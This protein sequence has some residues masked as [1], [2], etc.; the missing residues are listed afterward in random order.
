MQPTI[1][2]FA[3]GSSD[4]HAYRARHFN[5][6]DAPAMMGVS[7]YRSRT[8]LIREV[9]TGVADE[10]D[11][12]K[13]RLFDR[14]HAAEAAIRPMI[15]RLITDELYPATLS[16]DVQGL[17][18]SA[19]MDGWN[20]A[21]DTAFECK[22]WNEDLA[23]QVRNGELAPHYFWQLEQ[24]LLVSGAERVIF[25]TGDGEERLETLEYRPVPGRAEQLIAG[26]KQFEA[27]VA[28]YE[29][30]QVKAELVAA[31]IAGFGALTIRVEG[32]VLASNMD[33]F[34]ANAEAFLTQLPRPDQLQTDQDF[35]DAEAAVKAC[36]EA[37]ARI[38]A[39]TES[40]LA[41][42]VDIDALLRTAGSVSEAIRQAR[43]VLEKAV[44]AEKENRRAQIVADGAKAVRDYYD[45]INESLGEHRIQ[46]AQSLQLDL[47]AAIKGKKSLA[48]MEDAVSTTAANI[49]IAAS[50]QAERI[51]ANVA[52]LNEHALHAFLFQDRVQLCATKAPDD[53]RNLVAARISQHQ[54]AEA[55]KATALREQI[56]KEEEAKAQKKLDDEAAER[57]AQAQRDAAKP[58]PIQEPE[59]AQQA[60]QQSAPVAQPE[61]PYMQAVPVFVE[62]AAPWA[63]EGQK[64]KLGEINALIGPLTISADGLRQ[65]GFEPVATERGA[66]L[67]A[68]D[69][70]PDMCEQ[71]IR[72]LRAAALGDRY[73]LAA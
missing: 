14:G 71:M 9:A 54:Q 30:Q 40:T 60:I 72:V 5:A 51:R 67:Y 38:K 56:R 45:S 6:S 16:R 32:R 1:H 52:V 8:S 21:G 41:E 47:A 3:Q 4:W 11:E 22:L 23:A 35:V 43:L 2:K 17:P 64:I 65:L 25:A 49:K 18:L 19:S 62:D 12:N 46:P 34:K 70:V 7:K 59:P 48:S 15:E 53:L 27:D 42:M 28:A 73:P 36:A 31:P 26:W 57:A 10:V 37:E 20:M 66:K 39:A 58:G 44:K 50:Q 68:A 63:T 24:Q 29:P 61:K 69:Q 13:Q 33:A 55:A